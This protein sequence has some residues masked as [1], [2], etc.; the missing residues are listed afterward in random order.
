MIFTVAIE[1]PYSP[2]LA[3]V[4]L[5]SRMSCLTASTYLGGGGMFSNDLC[6]LMTPLIDRPRLLRGGLAG[7]VSSGGNG[8]NVGNVLLFMFPWV[9][10]NTRWYNHGLD[11]STLSASVFSMCL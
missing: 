5:L 6:G 3:L 7:G 8:P 11:I 9:I 1:A 10:L 4:Y 2:C